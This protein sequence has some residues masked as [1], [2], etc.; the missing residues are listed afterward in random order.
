MMSRRALL[1]AGLLLIVGSS[2]V[3]SYPQSTAEEDQMQND[4]EFDYEGVDQ[5]A[6]SPQTKSINPINSET[7]NRTLTVM[8]IRGEDVVLKCDVGSNLQATDVV[9]L[10][11]F[12]KNVI[13]NGKSLVQPNFELN[14]NYDLTIL[15]AS[16]QVA[17]TYVCKVLPSGSVVNTKVIIADHSLDAIA[18]ESSTSAAGSSSSFLGYTLLGSVLLLL[19]M[20]KH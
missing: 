14:A 15:K 3:L 18:P 9:V 20:G 7:V 17:G 1:I 13:S 2:A 12:G 6:P 8:G 19:G 5:S 10:W 4:E 11:F 16:S